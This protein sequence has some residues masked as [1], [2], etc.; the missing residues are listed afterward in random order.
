[1]FGFS[2]PSRSQAGAVL[3]ALSRSLAIIEFD[4]SGTILSANE[5]FC[6]LMGYDLSEIQGR[7]HSLFIEPAFVRSPD[8]Q[9]FWAK[10]SRGE[11]DA[12][13]YKRIGKG[14]KEVWIQASYNPVINANGRV[15]KIVKV[16]TDIT[17]EKL[18]NAEYES[19]I[20]AI[21]RVQ[22]MI[23]FTPAGDVITANE[24]FLKTLGYRIEEIQG[25]HHSLFVEP[26]YARSQEY[27]DFWKKL[28]RGEYIAAEFKRIGKGGKEVWIQASYNPIFDQNGKV[29][30][31][32]KFATDVTERVRAVNEIGLGLAQLADNNLS[33]RIEK[34]FIP[35]FEKLRSD[36]N[37][38][39]E[40][41]LSTML[42]IT[43]STQT[44]QS[45]TQ[46]IS[47]A[48][49]DL[50]R[51]TE[52]QAASLEETAAALDQI[53]ATVKKAAEGALHA[54]QIV[55]AAN[56]DAKK[57][58]LVVR[59][60]V[61]AMDGIAKSAQ[62][63][64]QIIGVIDEIAF[65]TNLL[66]LNA[67]V[68]AARAGDAGRGFAVV[69]LEV[70]ALAQRSAEAAK[71]IKSLIM[72][73]TSEVDHGVKLVAETG[74]TLENIM[75]QVGEINHLVNAIAEGTKEQAVGLEQVNTA[76]NQ[77]DQVT[78]QNAAM[79]EESTAASHALSQETRQLSN[80]VGQFQIGALCDNP[81][82]NGDAMPFAL[83][84]GAPDVF[85]TFREPA[86]RAVSNG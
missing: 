68:E 19:K 48:A 58:G 84:K 11:F 9:E 64:N 14:G 60:T 35:A 56:E 70:R 47:T 4:P 66:A 25:R 27:Q 53:T 24:N 7:H 75:R 23:D 29:V 46:E 3:A 39:L 44:I 63:I 73:S 13:E 72:A 80:L 18:R 40:K 17:G 36:F 69:A 28:N 78:Q 57:N 67:G 65:Q 8:Y 76:I 10:L 32:T 54:R 86:L 52:Q 12:R 83:Q 50:S 51:R 79:V 42:Q 59:R 37:L 21:S 62:Q 81:R 45:G 49:D 5:N 85:Q 30:Q 82:R 20:N 61:E 15:M 34:A 1:M 6:D 16:A 55:V 43:D 38:S 26:A 33:Y 31:I 22:A 74:G 2:V 41:L 71:E 77:M